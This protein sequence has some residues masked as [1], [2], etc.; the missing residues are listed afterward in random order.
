MVKSSSNSWLHVVLLY[1][2]S[3]PMGKKKQAEKNKRGEV[4][5]ICHQD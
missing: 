1:Y 5:E 2:G 4:L 3:F